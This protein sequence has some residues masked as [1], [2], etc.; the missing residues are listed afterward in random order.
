MRAS[1]GEPGLV[2]RHIRAL[3]TDVGGWELLGEKVTSELGSEECVGEVWWEGRGL[4]RRKCKVTELL[5][6]RQQELPVP[7]LTV[8][9][10]NKPVKQ[11]S[12]L[13]PFYHG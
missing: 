8:I 5:T 7:A 3:P 6:F 13:L 9:P 12:S 2:K 10:C 1:D 11:T 4:G